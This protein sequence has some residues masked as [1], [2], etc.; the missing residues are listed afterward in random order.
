MDNFK[1]RECKNAILPIADTLEVLQGKWK[2]LILLSLTFG[3]HGFRELER[4]IPKISPRMLS[5]ELKLLEE[6]QLVNRKVMS[7]KPIT[8]EYSLTTHGKTLKPVLFAL[9]DWGVSHRK[10]I[11]SV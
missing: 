9:R 10:K 4:Q 5:K 2:L 3:N 8:V 1:I 11:F 7:T 6:N